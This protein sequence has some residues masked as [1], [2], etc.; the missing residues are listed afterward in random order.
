MRFPLEVVVA[1]K[2][3]STCRIHIKYENNVDLK[4]ETDDVD[5]NLSKR[6][7]V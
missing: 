3:D 4:T 5:G 1:G 6:Y 7:A 2:Q